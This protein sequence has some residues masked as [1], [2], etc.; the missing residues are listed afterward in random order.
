[1]FLLRN[2]A[3]ED[4][5]NQYDANS[6][7]NEHQEPM[8]IGKGNEYPEPLGITKEGKTLYKIDIAAAEKGTK[9]YN[10]L[11]TLPKNTEVH[12]AEG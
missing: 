12:F 7:V 5:N 8:K 1:M 6:D 4:I 10:I 9:E 11:N 3:Q 2:E